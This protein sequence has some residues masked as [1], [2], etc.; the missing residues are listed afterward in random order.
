M[1]HPSTKDILSANLT[2]KESQEHG[3]V[4]IGLGNHEKS[5]FSPEYFLLDLFKD[6]VMNMVHFKLK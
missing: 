3:I 6:S 5:R 4:I 2:K 1:F